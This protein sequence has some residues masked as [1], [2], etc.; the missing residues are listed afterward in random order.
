MKLLKEY[1]ESWKS[2]IYIYVHKFNVEHNNM[3]NI[4]K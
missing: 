2:D 4:I 3:A 1:N